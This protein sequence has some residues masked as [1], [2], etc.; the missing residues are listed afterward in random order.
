MAGVPS[1]PSVHIQGEEEERKVSSTEEE[2]EKQ[3]LLLD[4]SS[5]TTGYESTTSVDVQRTPSSLLS[6]WRRRWKDVIALVVL[7]IAYFIVSAAYSIIAPFFPNEVNTTTHFGTC[8]QLDSVF[9]LLQAAEKGST[10]TI[11][12][13]IVSASPL[14]V[15]ITSPLFGYFVRT[16]TLHSFCKPC[17]ILL[18]T[19]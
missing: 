9:R 5:Q 10:P 13:L 7:W 3:P 18:R 14:C 11:T 6:P 12:G 4:W 19:F 16:R 17:T 15:V 2:G 1:E 8:A